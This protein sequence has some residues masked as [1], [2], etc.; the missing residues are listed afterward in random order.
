MEHLIGSSTAAIP[1][2]ILRVQHVN[3][4]FAS[5]VE[6]YKY[7]HREQ[8]LATVSPEAVK[9]GP[10]WTEDIKTKTKAHYVNLVSR[11]MLGN[12]F[13]HIPMLDFDFYEDAEDVA[14]ERLHALLNRLELPNGFVAT[15]GNGLHYLSMSIITEAGFATMMGE[16]TRAVP[17]YPNLDR[18]WVDWTQDVGFGQLRMTAGG[19]KT[20][21]PTIVDI[22]RLRSDAYYRSASKYHFGEF[23][24][25]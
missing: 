22:H 7:D 18:K 20:T 15:S 13:G 21:V 12:R 3:S 11:I 10:N 17:H 2:E 6:M 24:N 8:R 4:F 14:R 19:E 25:Y 16:L 1:T 5:G 23:D 9:I